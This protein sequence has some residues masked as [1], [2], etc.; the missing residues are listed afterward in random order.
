MRL[1]LCFH[2]ELVINEA[3]QTLVIML[4]VSLSIRGEDEDIMQLA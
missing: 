3:L 4:N 2:E 1:K